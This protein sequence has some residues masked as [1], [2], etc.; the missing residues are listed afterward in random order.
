MPGRFKHHQLRQLMESNPPQSSELNVLVIGIMLTLVT[1][2]YL[3]F[4]WLHLA[5]LW[6]QPQYQYFP[7][8]IAAVMWLLGSRWR[9]A[10]KVM[11]GNDFTQLTAAGVCLCWGLLAVATLLFSPWLA[12][13]SLIL[14]FGVGLGQ[15][16]H[17]RKIQNAFGI[18]VITCLLLPI[19]LGLDRK[20]VQ[21]LQ[22][23]S[24]QLSS[25]I[26]D[27]IGVMHVMDGNVLKTVEKRFFV[28]EAC[29]GIVSAMSVVTCATIYSVWKNRPTI[30]FLLNVLLAPLWAMLLNVGRISIIALA[31]SYWH[32]DLSSGWQHESLGLIL[33]L[34]TFG[35]LICTDN[36]LG[37]ALAPIDPSKLGHQP[38]RLIQCFN[39]CICWGSTS[40][41]K[42]GKVARP[43]N[44]SE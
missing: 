40:E 32:I 25:Q 29:S 37:V 39:R 18:W 36:L 14:L 26:L 33:F 13:L 20:L 15:V 1:L 41:S 34:L 24:S 43:I 16:T 23:F 9:S 2:G 4:V 31:Y 12:M 19:P 17:F 30:H 11:A 28:D 10:E 7:F 21:A 35:A 44:R 27:A 38:G 5:L 3:P 22:V 6:Q 8:V 42:S